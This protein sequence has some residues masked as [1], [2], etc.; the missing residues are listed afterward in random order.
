MYRGDDGKPVDDDTAFD[1]REIARR[2]L[3]VWTQ[4]DP[5]REANIDPPT[6]SNAIMQRAQL[7]LQRE[8]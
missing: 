3:L 7:L 5:A 4:A 8:Q 2:L 6:S 1:M